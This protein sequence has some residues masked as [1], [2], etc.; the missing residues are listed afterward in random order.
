MQKRR[1]LPNALLPSPA[2]LQIRYSFCKAMV[3][4]YEGL[5]VSQTDADVVPLPEGS[6]T[7]D[8]LAPPQLGYFCPCCDYTTINWDVLRL[9]FR[10][11][12]CTRGYKTC[13]DLLCF[14]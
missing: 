9:Y 13:G 14:L 11:T 12:Q 7:L 8:F 5:S 3:S 2:L 6:S 10:Q 4:Q 1:A